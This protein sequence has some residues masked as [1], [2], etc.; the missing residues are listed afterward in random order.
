MIPSATLEVQLT[1]NLIGEKMVSYK[2][3]NLQLFPYELSQ[4]FL[5]GH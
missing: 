1:T 4:A 5:V 2:Y 3:Y